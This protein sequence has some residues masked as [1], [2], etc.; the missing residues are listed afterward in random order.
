MGC[1]C[2]S[3]CYSLRKGAAILSLL[4]LSYFFPV[5][6]NHQST[7]LNLWP[8]HSTRPNR[9]SPPSSA[10]RLPAVH[11]PG[12]RASAVCL[13]GACASARA[14][15]ANSRSAHLLHVPKRER[16]LG[17]ARHRAAACGRHSGARRRAADAATTRAAGRRRRDR[18]THRRGSSAYDRRA[19]SACHAAVAAATSKRRRAATIQG[20]IGGNQWS[21]E[22]SGGKSRNETDKTAQS[23]SSQVSPHLRHCN[24][25]SRLLHLPSSHVPYAASDDALAR[26][27]FGCS[28]CS[29]CS[30]ST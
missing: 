7:V 15:A 3:C 2:C 9:P 29:N 21:D 23:A 27:S 6:L 13:S 8:G 17:D 25:H 24:V 5:S 26:T 30:S 10:P 11:L 18:P 19:A 28:S 12:T 20:S 4:L 16:A 22:K 1:T 14:S